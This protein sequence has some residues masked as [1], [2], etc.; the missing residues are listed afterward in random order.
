[1][2]LITLYLD[3]QLLNSIILYFFSLGFGFAQ[4]IK[5]YGVGFLDNFTL[6]D[7]LDHL[8]QFLFEFL[9]FIVFC[10][11]FSLLF[12]NGFTVVFSVLVFLAELQIFEFS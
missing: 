6:I 8:F 9:L 7:F 4:R 11:L 3:V 12:I 1:M 5:F 2:I 10:V